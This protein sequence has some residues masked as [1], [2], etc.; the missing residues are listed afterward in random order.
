MD[1]GTG[2]KSPL[3][4][5]ILLGFICQGL[6]WDDFLLPTV[7]LLLWVICLRLRRRDVIL[8]PLAEC[9]VLLGGCIAGFALAINMGQSTHFFIGHGLTMIQ[10]A[11]LMRK[12]GVREKFFSFVVALFQVGVACTVV[13]DFRFILIL[14]AAI[15]LVPRSL[16]ELHAAH[17]DIEGKEPDARLPIGRGY[18]L[19]GLVMVVFFLFFPRTFLGSP[20]QL[21]RPHSEQGSMLES[22]LDPT[23][24]GSAQSSQI[25]LQVEAKSIGYMRCLSLVE[26]DGVIWSAIARVP[27]QRSPSL[28]AAD[29]P[30]Y[31]H[32]RVR[33]KNAAFLDHVLPTD[34]RV[35]NIAGNFFRYP[36]Q[37]AHGGIV[38]DSMWNTPK[39]IYEYWTDLKPR[40]M[41]LGL[42]QKRLY[43]KCPDQS[44]R[45]REWL[46]GILAGV[47][48][49]RDKAS[50][51]EAWLKSN[52]KYELGTPELSRFH[53][54]D[55]FIFTQKRGHCERFAAAMATL[56]RLEGIPSRVV[57][58][59]VPN[60]RDWFTGWFNVRMKD[61]H[62]WAEGWFSE[63]GWVQ[64]DATPRASQPSDDSTLRDW[65]E[66]VDFFWYSQVVNFD[67]ATQS[68]LMR[69]S[70]QT[71]STVWEQLRAIWVR[72]ALATAGVVLVIAA[73]LFHRRRGLRPATEA[74]RR[75]RASAIIGSHYGRMLH[76]L[77]QKG[78]ERE[79]YQ[80]PL[81]FLAG[82]PEES[83]LRRD[84]EYVTR[85]FCATR[86]GE[87]ELSSDEEIELGR[88]IE[89]LRTIDRTPVHA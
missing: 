78:F 31:E 84:V 86:Y 38:C 66:A 62:A 26:F 61:A 2:M 3:Q 29:L 85:L 51:I 17:F 9:G 44:D 76:I 88:A 18:A 4:Q 25:I 79:E 10:A 74:E 72:L 82:L 53:P 16:I 57:I 13:L 71:M 58:G 42:G 54:M 35:V 24:G 30:S 28:A 56:L 32:R 81:E 41:T 34:G 23:R 22:L 50:R 65:I 11:R 83:A 27:W 49:P 39:N 7:N 48:N 6:S 55:D 15:V 67:V 1:P 5:L 14:I 40:P 20:I 36:A 75:R 89:R 69:A 21:S 73:V 64:F 59:Y 70:V 8:P 43:T 46:K 80:T 63:S 87:A 37:N 47:E 68:E 19:I 77:E 52:L 33:V 12:L 45:L 60:S